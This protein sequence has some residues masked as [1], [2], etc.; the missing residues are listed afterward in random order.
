MLAAAAK[1]LTSFAF[2]PLD[3]MTETW[4]DEPCSP[5]SRLS[6]RWIELFRAGS[7][8]YLKS[9]STVFLESYKRET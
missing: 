9:L 6:L 2:V 8:H 7:E 4:T 1:Q 3:P 5:C